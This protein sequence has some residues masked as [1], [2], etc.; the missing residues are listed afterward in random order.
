[1][2]SPSELT[3]ELEWSAMA[4]TSLLW[5]VQVDP[6]LPVLELLPNGL[7]AQ[8]HDVWTV[9]IC[10][11]CECGTACAGRAAQRQRPALTPGQRRRLRHRLGLIPP[12]S[13][14]SL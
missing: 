6:W 1:M 9:L 11:P 3:H 4:D 12:E 2:P 13:G 10:A 14:T 7:P 5:R 8:T